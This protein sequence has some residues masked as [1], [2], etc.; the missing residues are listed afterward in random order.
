MRRK[1]KRHPIEQLSKWCFLVPFTSVLF[2]IVIAQLWASLKLFFWRLPEPRQGSNLFFD[3]CRNLDKS[4][5]YFLTFAGMS[6]RLK[7]IF[8]HLPECRQSSNLFFD[9][10]RNFDKSQIIF[11]T[12]AETSASSFTPKR[13]DACLSTSPLL[14]YFRIN[15]ELTASPYLLF[16]PSLVKHTNKLQHDG[17][18]CD[19][20]RLNYLQQDFRYPYLLHS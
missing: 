13:E 4:Q 15:G 10:C 11:L 20:L 9:V 16:Q 3:V 6:A 12:F 1:T 7:F 18:V 8:W 19:R 5:I 14:C 17:F 2:Y